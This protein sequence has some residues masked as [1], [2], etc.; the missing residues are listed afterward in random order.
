MMLPCNP[1]SSRPRRR[2]R[3]PLR[4]SGRSH[5]RRPPSAHAAQVILSGTVTGR[6]GRRSYF[7]PLI[8]G[9]HVKANT[10][11]GGPQSYS[12]RTRGCFSDCMALPGASKRPG[13]MDPYVAEHLSEY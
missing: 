3:D 12:L 10:A 9:F 4:P 1:P 6:T 8:S 7:T 5:S 13:M 11:P 2:L